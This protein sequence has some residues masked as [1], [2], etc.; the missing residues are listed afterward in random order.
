[1]NGERIAAAMRQPAILAIVW[2]CALLVLIGTLTK[3]PDQ[4]HRRDFSNYYESAWAMRHRIDPYSTNLTPI[5][6]QLGLETNWLVHASE[7]PPFLLCF[8]PLTRMRPR[9][10]FWLWTAIN[11]SALAIAMYLLLV[12]RSGLS[13]H[14]ALLL[15]GLTLMSA[16]VNLNFYW[17]QSQLIVLALMVAAMRAMERDRD[18]TAG[19]LIAAAALLRAYPLLLV[20]YF[21]IR[22]KWRAVIF[23]TVGIGAGGFATVAILGLSQTLSFVH[24][25]LWLTD[26]RVVNRVDNLSLGPFVSRMFW[27][28][29][30][31]APGSSVDWVRRAAMAIADVVVLGLTIRATLEYSDRRDPDWRIYSLWVATAVMLTPVGWHHY[32]VLLAIPF[33]QMVASATEGRSSSRAIWMAALAYLLSAISLR[34]FSRFMVPPPTAFQLALPWLAR[35]LEETSFVALLTGYFAAYWF[36]TDQF[37]QVPAAQIVIAGTEAAQNPRA[38]FGSTRTTSSG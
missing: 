11:F 19:L 15:A 1:M 2:T 31:T 36:A 18:G 9:V 34:A 14:T 32:L 30:G 26:Y 37:R 28:L 5:G 29:T 35:A 16:P 22:R 4:W 17:G 33:V 13:G 10:A 7:T 38:L 20:G 6:A 12:R 8:E 24:G 27:A 21:V 3:M 23:A 25:A